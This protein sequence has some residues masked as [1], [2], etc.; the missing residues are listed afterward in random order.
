MNLHL[1]MHVFVREV[2]AMELTK[3]MELVKAMGLRKARG[4][5]GLEWK[6]L[7]G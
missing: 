6:S 4:L 1:L 2:E 5:I 3:A 7:L